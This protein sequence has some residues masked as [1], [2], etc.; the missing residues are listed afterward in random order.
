MPAVAVRP[1]RHGEERQ[2]EVVEAQA[3]RFV[4]DDGDSDSTEARQDA[5]GFGGAWPVVIAGGHHDRR[6][7]ESRDIGSPPVV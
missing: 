5:A 6:A 1:V 7:G 3:L 2:A 4:L